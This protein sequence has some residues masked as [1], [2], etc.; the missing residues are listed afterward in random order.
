MVI[1]HGSHVPLSSFLQSWYF[2]SNYF[3]IQGKIKFPLE[4]INKSTSIAIRYLI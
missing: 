4:Y 1:L 2:V 3:N